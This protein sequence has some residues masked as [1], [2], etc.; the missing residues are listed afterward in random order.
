MKVSKLIF[1]LVLI[2][3]GVFLWGRAAGWFYLS[4]GDVLRFIFPV[5][6][7]A[8]GIWMIVRRKH[9]E[10]RV[11][12]E[13]HIHSTPPPPPNYGRSSADATSCNFTGES[14]TADAPDG[15]ERSFNYSDGTNQ[16]PEAGQ[17]GG[18]KFSKALGDMV[19][20][21]NGLDLKN[22]EV[23]YGIGDIEIRLSGGRLTHGLNRMVVSGFIGDIRIYVPRDMPYLAHCSN[24]IG[25]IEVV[26]R[27]ASGFGNTIDSQSEDYDSADAKLYLAVNS[28]IG[29]LRINTI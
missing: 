28:F 13:I 14:S 22:I 11:E 7:I 1:G 27:R 8:L 19:V 20:D 6:L 15:S 2:F 18:L 21:C 26:G 4:V 25:D 24:S 16:N 29:D 23:S 5:G 12:A 3:L 10:N 9:Q 17:S